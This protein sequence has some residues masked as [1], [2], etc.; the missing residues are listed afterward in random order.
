MISQGRMLVLFCIML[1]SPSFIYAGSDVA[2]SKDHPLISR[3]K[4]TYIKQYSFTDYDEYDIATG[5][6]MQGKNRPPVKTVEGKITTII[7]ETNTNKESVVRVFKNY[8]HSFKKAGFKKIFSCSNSACGPDFVLDLITKTPRKA[9]YLRFDPWNTNE[10]FSNYRYWSG[11]LKN[12]KKL[13]YIVLMV[14]TKIFNKYPVEVS[15]DIIEPEE[16]DLGLVTI[17]VNSL[18]DAI[19]KN[20][21]AVLKGIYF[22]YDKTVVKPESRDSLHVIAK[23]LRKNS[24]VRVYIVGH[25]DNS[26]SGSYNFG[27]SKRRAQSV[28]NELVTEHGIRRDRLEAVGVGPVAPATT[29]STDAGRAENRRV[30]IVLKAR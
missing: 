27:L 29:N 8:L 6:A 9:N 26:G 28:V 14:K 5:P 17:D 19:D 25:T 4:D 30:E 2:N 12:N 11:V 16:M 20:G 21:K 23:Y 7:Y 18:T 3:Y 13:A 24:G 15:L 1:A 10:K 22:D